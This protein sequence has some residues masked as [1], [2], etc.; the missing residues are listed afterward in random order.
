MSKYKPSIESR[1]TLE[2]LKIAGNEEEWQNDAVDKVYKE[3]KKRKIKPD[4]IK[5][6][7][8]DYKHYEN[9]FKQEMA[10]ESYKIIDFIFEPV[11]FIF[12]LLFQW[13]LKK[14]GYF[15]K[16]RQLLRI[17]IVVLFLVLFILLFNIL[18]NNNLI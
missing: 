4:K 11:R 9:I 6:A 18:N 2:L 13:E 15:R 7:K 1:S 3:L 10:N 17:R 8:E 16:S 5:Q 14:D 12:I